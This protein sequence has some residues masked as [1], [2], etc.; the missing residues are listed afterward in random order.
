MNKFKEG[1]KEVLAENKKFHKERLRKDY[2]CRKPLWII[3]VPAKENQLWT[4]WFPF[5]KSWTS[6]QIIYWDWL[7]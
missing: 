3:I 7:I 5:A 6:A 2:F 1:L 4:Y